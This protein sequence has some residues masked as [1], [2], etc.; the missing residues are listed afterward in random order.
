MLNGDFESLC[1]CYSV[2]HTIETPEGKITIQTHDA[3]KVLFKKIVQNYRTRNVTALIRY[4][5]TAEFRGSNRVEATHVSHQMSGSQRIMA[6]F[7]GYS[8]IE[9]IDNRWQ[10]TSTQF[11]IDKKNHAGAVLPA[12]IECCTDPAILSADI[13]ISKKET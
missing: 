12:I 8:V 13:E 5:E 2:P 1:H 7:H 10:L 4:C 3:L 6:P 9:F 11:A